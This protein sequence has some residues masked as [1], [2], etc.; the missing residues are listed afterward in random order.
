[1]YRHLVYGDVEA[2][3]EIIGAVWGVIEMTVNRMGSGTTIRAYFKV[4]HHLLLVDDAISAARVSMVLEK[5][6][7]QVDCLLIRQVSGDRRAGGMQ[8]ADL[9]M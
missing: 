2:S 7:T 1:M 9:V 5:M 4:L 3:H 8:Q 6:K